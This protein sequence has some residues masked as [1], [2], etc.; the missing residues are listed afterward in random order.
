[1]LVI[2][3]MTTACAMAQENSGTP[4]ISKA[5]SMSGPGRLHVETSGGGISVSAR[6]GNQVKVEMFVR[7]DGKELNRD[8]A[9]AQEVLENYDI[10]IS[11]SGNT[12]TATAEPKSSFNGWFGGDNTSISFNVY[13]PKQMS[14]KLNTSGGSIRLEG[15]EGTQNVNTSGGSLTLLNIEGNME[16]QTSGGSIT[17]EEYK[18]LL[19]ASTSGGSIKLRNA[20][21][22]LKVH[23]S[24]GN[25]KLDEIRGSVNAI[26]SG[27]GIDAKLLTL[28][29]DLTLKTSGGSIHATLP[30]DLGLDLDL[31]GNRV[32]TRLQNFNGE[33]EKD[34][35]RGSMNGGGIAV[36][37]STSGGSVN[38]D[39]Q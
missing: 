15:V 28:T 1:M 4:L 5:F 7:K 36:V 16:A 32:N 35:V 23:T 18:G 20:E 33:A 38:L 31:Q 8:N 6:E 29:N 3:I 22:N 9:D 12:I 27:G 2:F 24:G 39:Y 25:I 21:G 11:Q 19:E 34:R 14:T 37:M 30:K 10:D 26:T 17:I 13:V